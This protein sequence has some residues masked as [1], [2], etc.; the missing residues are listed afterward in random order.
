[1][2]MYC[3]WLIRSN[4]SIPFLG[5]IT[6]D[7]HWKELLGLATLWIKNTKIKASF[8][9]TLFIPNYCFEE[10]N[11][12][13]IETVKIFP[14]SGLGIIKV[15][16]IEIFLS[17]DPRCEIMCHGDQNQLGIDITWNNTVI[18]HDAGLDSYNLDSN[19]KWFESWQG[20]STCVINNTNPIVSN[21]RRKQLPYE[22]YKATAIIEKS[23]IY[24]IKATHTCFNR[25]INV[26]KI[27]REIAIIDKK[28]KITDAVLC[29]EISLYN[30][31]FHFGSSNITL[32][33]N[34]ILISDFELGNNFR[35]CFPQSLK[36]ELKTY[37][38]TLAYGVK[39]MG[40][41]LFLYADKNNYEKEFNYFIEK[42]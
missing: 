20:Q 35:F 30:V 1:M 12:S 8:Y 16:G 6:P 36:V 15:D 3:K 41:S 42:Q 33:N 7:I 32:N 38:I 26:S 5:H 23:G 13:I 2:V 21:W 37:P 28:I 4:S 17:N 27:S 14:K 40:N 39:T 9:S 31:I 29:N 18:V 25:L 10:N 19:R 11:G 22:Y 34:E 24:G